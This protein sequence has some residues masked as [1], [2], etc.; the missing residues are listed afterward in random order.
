MKFLSLFALALMPLCAQLVPNPIAAPTFTGSGLNDMSAGGQFIGTQNVTYT[1]TIAS[2][3]TPDKF[4]W[5][6]SDGGSGTSINITGGTCAALPAGSGWQTLSHGVQVCW[7]ANTGHTATDPWSVVVTA[8]GTIA[9]STFMQAGVGAVLRSDQS[10]GRDVVSVTDYGADPK[11]VNDSLAAFNFAYA[12]ADTVQVPLGLYRLSGT[13]TMNRLNTRLLCQGFGATIEYTGSSP[14]AELIEITAGSVRVENCGLQGGANVTD[15]LL[16]TDAV[17]GVV[18]RDMNCTAITVQTDAANGCLH[19]FN[20]DENKAENIHSSGQF[21]TYG[22]QFEDEAFSQVIRPKMEEIQRD[23]IRMFHGG[24]FECGGNHIVDGTSEGNG[25][26]VSFTGCGSSLS[27]GIDLEVNGLISGAACAAGVITYTTRFPYIN[28]PGVITVTGILDSLSSGLYNVSGPVTFIDATHLSIPSA[29][30]T[31]TYVG[32]GSM[33]IDFVDNSASNR[34][35]SVSG[36]F[37]LN[38]G[39]V[40]TSLAHTSLFSLLVNSGVRDLAL[41]DV[42]YNGGLLIDNGSCTTWKHVYNTNGNNVYPDRTGCQTGITVMGAI[43]RVA[44]TLPTGSTALNV[45]SATCSVGLATFTMAG[46]YNLPTNFAAT[47]TGATPSSWDISAL[48]ITPTSATTFTVSMTCP[49]SPYASGGAVTGSANNALMMVFSNDA[50][51]GLGGLASCPPNGLSGMDGTV[52]SGY[53]ASSLQGGSNTLNFCGSQA[54]SILTPRFAAISTARPSGQPV[55]LSLDGAG[56][57]IMLTPDSGAACLAAA[58]SNRLCTDSSGDISSAGQYTSGGNVTSTDGTNTVAMTG[59]LNPQ[60]RTTSGT[61]VGKLQSVPGSPGIFFGSESAD[62]ACLITNNTARLCFDASGAL[63]T[64]GFVTSLTAGT[65]NFVS[66]STGAVTVTNIGVTSLSA[67]TGIGLS[68]STGAITI[69]NTGA[70]GCTGHTT[71]SPA[72][73]TNAACTTTTSITYVSSISCP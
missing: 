72:L 25:T 45:S 28:V 58:G 55:Q 5:S 69:T 59:S 2:A 12:H 6:A 30:P 26:G 7:L 52:I 46:N 41:E 67:G 43:N 64:G 62:P 44:E 10:K 21:L 40:S 71:T 39:A 8:N 68:G 24:G 16:R 4:S 42:G 34:Y 65:G 14:L 47:I 56:A 60:V 38:P 33:N 36:S 37:I 32:Q 63:T 61:H 31:A 1:V 18:V 22:I 23:G 53:L 17:S 13:F 50:F 3:G 19:F 70:T 48:P 35:L 66:A 29:C 9:P 51:G 11:G 20:G 15:S 54:L 49:G 27:E 57:W 73:C